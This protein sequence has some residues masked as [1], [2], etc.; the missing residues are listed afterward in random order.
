MRFTEREL[1]V[2]MNNPREVSDRP[3]LLFTSYALNAIRNMIVIDEEDDDPDED[4]TPEIWGSKV[5]VSVFDRFISELAEDFTSGPSVT[6]HGHTYTVRKAS[7]IKKERLKGVFSFR[8]SDDMYIV[9]KSGIV[10]IDEGDDRSY[11]S[12]KN[13]LSLNREYL[14]KIIF[15]AEDDDH[16]GWD[17]LTDMEAAAYC[18]ALYWHRYNENDIEG[19]QK[20]YKSWHML[21]NREIMEGWTDRCRETGMPNGMYTF[22]ASNV[23]KWNE[24]NGQGSVVDDVG[25]QEADDYWYEKAVKSTFK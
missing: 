21:S 7:S 8:V 13:E 12:M 11:D 14:R 1:D 3:Y 4:E 18:W 23:R 19:F 20:K 5:P 24:L 17:K 9:E 6:I 15:V 2:L 22:S 10:N 25:K 16:D